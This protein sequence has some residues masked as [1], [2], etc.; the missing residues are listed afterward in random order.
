V[1]DWLLHL[2]EELT[3]GFEDEL[4]VWEEENR[5]TY[6]TSIER[7][8]IQKGLQEGLQKGLQEGIA[9]AL[10][11]KFGTGGKRLMPR[12]RQIRDVEELRAVLNAIP[13]AKRLQEIRD[14]LPARLE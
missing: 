14:R 13:L 11:L 1:I 12:V 8:G 3:Q 9:A 10:A 6:I 4:H 2:P 7:S 5:M